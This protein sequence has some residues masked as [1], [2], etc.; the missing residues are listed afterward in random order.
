MKLVILILVNLHMPGTVDCV[1]GHLEPLEKTSRTKEEQDCQ[2]EGNSLDIKLPVWHIQRRDQILRRMLL[3]KSLVL[4]MG[5]HE[6]N[7][8]AN[9]IL[10]RS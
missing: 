1:A 8:S 6:D 2:A 3:L 10:L 7:D 9:K 4:T 5:L